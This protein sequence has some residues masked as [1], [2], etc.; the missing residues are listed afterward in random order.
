M[1]NENRSRRWKTPAVLALGAIVGVML[2][3]PPAG[4]HFLPSINHIWNHIKP[5][6]DAT[7]VN[8]KGSLP[9]GK[10]LRGAYSAWGNGA[11]GFIGDAVT[12][13][14]PLP[15][16]L[17]PAHVHFIT[18]GTTTD[19]AGPGH[20][21]PGHLCVYEHGSGGAT[22]G[23]IYHLTQGVGASKYGFGIYFD[24]ANAANWSF[25]EWAVTAP[26]AGAARPIAP[27]GTTPTP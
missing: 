10:T 21:A 17:D 12:F 23:Q 1:K 26:L 6:A 18:S 7:Y 22:L 8:E 13:R 3:A 2:V 16:E 5:K 20:A 14:S 27:R 4:A 19:C 24:T 11:G 25:G 15:A 9:P